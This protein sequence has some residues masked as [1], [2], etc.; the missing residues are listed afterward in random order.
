M[1]DPFWPPERRIVEEGYKNINLPMK[2]IEGPNFQMETEWTLSQ[3]M[4]YLRTWSAVKKYETEIGENPADKKYEELSILWGNPERKQ[5]IRW[6]L[7]L[8]VWGK[9]T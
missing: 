2:V 3:L 9:N 8:K 4:G 7:T 1:L 5:K 6:P